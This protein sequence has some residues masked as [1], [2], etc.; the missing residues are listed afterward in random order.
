MVGM[1]IE[2]PPTAGFAGKL[3]LD[4]KRDVRFRWTSPTVS[5]EIEAAEEVVELR[6]YAKQSTP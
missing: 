4:L 6:V 3:G 1:A 5:L 2:P